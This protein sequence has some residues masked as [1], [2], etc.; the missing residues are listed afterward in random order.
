[1]SLGSTGVRGPRAGRIAVR[2]AQGGRLPVNTTRDVEFSLK[3]SDGREV[4]WKERCI[5]TSVMQPLL[6]LGK[7]M[8][9]GWIPSKDEAGLTL[10][11]Q[12]SGLSVPIDFKGNSLMVHA[13]LRRVIGDE[14]E[15]PEAE[16]EDVCV[17]AATQE[18]R[19]RMTSATPSQ[20]LIDASY[21]W[22]TLESTGHFVWRGRSDRYIDPATLVPITWP[23][24]TTLVHTDGGWRMLELCVE[25]TQLADPTALFPCGT[26]ECI[27]VLSMNVEDPGEFGVEVERAAEHVND[28]GQQAG[29]EQVGGDVPMPDAPGGV[30]P[31]E[32]EPVAPA[33]ISDAVEVPARPVPDNVV[34]VN[35]VGLS[36]GSTLGALRAGCKYLNL[37]QSGS[38]QRCFQ[39][40][41]A[42]VEKERLSA[43]VQVAEQA[44]A[45]D[46]RDP[47]MQ[48]MPKPPSEEARLLHEITHLPFANW[49]S[50]CIAMK[51]VPDQH[52]LVPEGDAREHPTIS[53]DLFYTGFSSGGEIE[54]TTEEQGDDKAKLTC[55]IIHC[56]HTDA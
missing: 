15:E 33:P 40:L 38:K 12:E 3:A 20:E 9:G 56:N 48:F 43:E 11:H 46:S 51:S 32:F 7:L 26:C 41:Q 54:S 4:I 30:E 5:V 55:L 35:G 45:G 6:A 52:R 8:R 13:T 25:W 44:R 17:N 14:D 36:M 34:T 50:H 22:Q 42:Y 10:Q 27:V 1:M 21:G 53:F 39:R 29:G 19:V 31:E 16:T 49:C 24:R 18:L 28:S 2:D 23:N 47:N 37:S